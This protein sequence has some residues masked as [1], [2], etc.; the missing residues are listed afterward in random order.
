MIMSDALKDVL[1]TKIII[2]ETYER[3][4][5]KAL[6]ESHALNDQK[7]KTLLSKK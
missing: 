6:E 1:E 5:K 2:K 7:I 4:M 3:M